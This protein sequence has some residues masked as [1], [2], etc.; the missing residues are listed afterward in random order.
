[1]D[2]IHK[3][4]LG[5]HCYELWRSSAISQCSEIFGNTPQAPAFSQCLWGA[6]LC[7]WLWIMKDSFIN[8][9]LFIVLVELFFKEGGLLLSIFLLFPL[10]ISSVLHSL[11]LLLLTSYKHTHT[12]AIESF[13]WTTGSMLYTCVLDHNWDENI[14]RSWLLCSTI[15]V[16]YWTLTEKYEQHSRDI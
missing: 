2:C 14:L 13:I 4:I 7:S 3:E 9:G 10:F 6:T 12:L 15:Q 16:L 11:A 8:K 5:K 1:M